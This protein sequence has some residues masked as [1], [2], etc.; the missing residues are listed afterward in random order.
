MSAS[1][2]RT[3]TIRRDR[4]WRWAFGSPP[5][6]RQV[7]THALVGAAEAFFAVSLAGSIF[8]NVSLDAARP[9]VILYLL[10]TMAPFAILA[11]LIGPVIDRVTGGLRLVMAVT[12]IGRAV[13]CLLLARDLRTLLLYPEAFGVLVLGKTYS[14]A[15]NA[16]VPRLVDHPDELVAANAR[17]ARVS[18]VGSSAGGAI[19]AGLFALTS[20]VAVL[21]V[22]ALI[23]AVAMVAA[24]RLPKPDHRPASRTWT[25]FEELHAPRLVMA[26]VAMSV[27]KAAVGFLLFLLGFALRRASEPAWLYGVVF[28]ASGIG[29]LAGTF[30]APRLRQRISEE[31][32]LAG[33]LGVPAA[34]AVAAAVAPNR[35]SILAVAF[36]I[37]LGSTIGRQSFDSLVQ[38]DAPDADR[39]RAFAR[40]ETGFQL[41]WVIGA[42]LPVVARPPTWLGIL[43]LGLLLAAGCVVYVVGVRSAARRRAEPLAVPMLVAAPTE[44][45]MSIELLHVAEGFLAEQRYALAVVEAALAV[46]LC[47]EGTRRSR[48]AG[49]NP[50]RTELGELRAR[51][52]AGGEVTPEAA[53]RAVALARSCLRSWERP[54]RSPSTRRRVAGE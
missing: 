1:G 24:L 21:W 3:G 54:S 26:A 18:M 7:E 27:L 39:G 40:F 2:G 6:S 31:R 32:M 12:C 41:A 4:W 44:Q 23:Y 48:S 45:S 8:F 30:V 53:A 9:R 33:A 16:F 47:V 10:L 36:A 43:V 22:G 49:D 37:G 51:A 29:G 35:F 19:A 11:P 42:L 52:A 50:A 25:E 15:R 38:R 20:A 13:L 46:D 28:A 5:L 34:V 17:L 14:V